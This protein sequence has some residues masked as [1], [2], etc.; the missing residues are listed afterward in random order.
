MSLRAKC[1]LL[2]VAFEVTLAATIFFTMRYIG[3]YFEEAADAF[4]V[5]RAH[6]ADITRLRGLTP[7]SRRASPM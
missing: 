6:I 4:S 7:A 5:S 2:L 1:A 3:I